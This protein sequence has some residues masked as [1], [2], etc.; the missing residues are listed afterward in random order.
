MKA[1]LCSDLGCLRKRSRNSGG[2]TDLV[3]GIRRRV[4]ECLRCVHANLEAG[5]NCIEI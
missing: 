2:S 4:R 1:L 3:V 5:L